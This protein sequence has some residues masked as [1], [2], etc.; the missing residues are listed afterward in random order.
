VAPFLSDWLHRALVGDAESVHLADFPEE[1]A[2][3]MEVALERGMDAV[4][5]LS[6]LG[7]AAR[8]EV[9]IRVRQP[10]GAVYAVIPEGVETGDDLLAILRDELNVKRV[11]FMHAA[12]ELVT[13]T[14]KPNFK[15]LGARF[16]KHTPKVADLV[17]ALP[18]D[19]IAAFR[20]GEALS[21][22]AGGESFTLAEGDFEVIQ[23]AQGDFVI[24]S[25]GGFTLAVDPALT[26]ELRAEGVAREVVNRV[27]KLRK[28]TGLEVSDRIRLGVFGD[29]A[30]LAD[31]MAACGEL[32]RSETLAVELETG[33]ATDFHGYEADREVDLDGITAIIALRRVNRT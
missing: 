23:N 16:G 31:A 7:R 19:R 10:L 11:E 12:E 21:V 6:T 9:G 5:T 14:A 29:D 4:R 1:D 3:R 22:E 17:R 2:A 8:E 25:E 32:V 20:R 24:E 18:S 28:D 26:P 30:D 13:F 15:A 27:Q 33:S